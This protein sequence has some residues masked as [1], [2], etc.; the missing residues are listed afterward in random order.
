MINTF[1]LKSKLKDPLFWLGLVTL[2][3][4][5]A[6]AYLKIFILEAPSRMLWYSAVG[7]LIITIGLFKRSSFLLVAMFCA[8]VINETVWTLSFFTNLLFHRDVTNVAAYAFK[9]NYPKFRF[10]VTMYHLILVPSIVIG[11][12]VMRK[13]HRFA[14]IGAYIFALVLGILTL[15]F[16]DPLGENVNC[17]VRETIGSCRLYFSWFYRFKGF[18][19]IFIVSA[20]LGLFFYLPINYLICLLGR[21]LGWKVE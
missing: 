16:P 1:A 7:L 10:I 15:F 20:F 12:V 13:V 3:F 9:P 4:W 19:F 11:L 17:I 14:W 5:L 8:L 6:D 21:K 18:G 2:S